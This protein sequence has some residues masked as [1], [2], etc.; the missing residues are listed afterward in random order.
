MDENDN[1]PVIVTSSDGDG[2]VF[3]VREN[4]KVDTLIGVVV[5]ED[6]DQNSTLR[7]VAFFRAKF[8]SPQQHC[9]LLGPPFN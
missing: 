5:A 7:Y 1:A 2:I 8:S 6:A 9:L 3:H 4:A